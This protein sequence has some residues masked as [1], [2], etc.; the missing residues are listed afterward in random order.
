ML[1]NILGGAGGVRFVGGSGG[2]G[3]KQKV[4][5]VKNRKEKIN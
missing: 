5:W 3:G 4:K 2:G 1:G